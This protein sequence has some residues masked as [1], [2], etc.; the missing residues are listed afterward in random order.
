[1]GFPLFFST[2]FSILSDV[3]N[4]SLLCIDA[5]IKN[6]LKSPGSDRGSVRLCMGAGV[7]I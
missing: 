5:G 4:A 7:G 1:M 2:F 3:G 6:V